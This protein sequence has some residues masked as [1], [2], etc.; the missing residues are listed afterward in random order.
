MRALEEVMAQVEAD[1][2]PSGR[3]IRKARAEVEAI[4][5][6]AKTYARGCSTMAEAVA[7]DDL[8]AAIAKDAP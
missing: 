2:L 1:L 6:V 7:L 4:K 3:Q 8:L 5:R